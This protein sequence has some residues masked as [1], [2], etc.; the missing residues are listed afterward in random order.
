MESM[1]ALASAVREYRDLTHDTANEAADALHLL[2]LI[3]RHGWSVSRTS[4]MWNVD[5]GVCLGELEDGNLEEGHSAPTL[6][7]A[8]TEA[9][10][11]NRCCGR[12][13]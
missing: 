2:G 11:C 13:S 10:K 3:E 7:E 4:R 1:E 12:E 9:S 5:S 6:I 8:L